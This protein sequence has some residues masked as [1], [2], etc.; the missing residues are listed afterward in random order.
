MM[1]MMMAMMI[2]TLTLAALIVGSGGDAGGGGG[3]VRGARR[4]VVRGYEIR[5]PVTSAWK[6]SKTSR[7]S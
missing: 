3:C 4:S 2:T 5:D 6:S 7:T 1:V